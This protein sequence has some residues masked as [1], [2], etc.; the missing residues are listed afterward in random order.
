MWIGIY[1][2][3]IR[4]SFSSLRAIKIFKPSTK[5]INAN[6]PNLE[7]GH[8]NWLLA[9]LIFA[10]IAMQALGFYSRISRF[11]CGCLKVYLKTVLKDM[12]QFKLKKKKKKFVF[13][14]KHAVLKQISI[15]W[16]LNRLEQQL[17]LK[18]V[19]KTIEKQLL[20]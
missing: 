17:M 4:V 2:I 7:Q 12:L 13:L 8:A 10:D 18:N 15:L 14:I 3:N 16:H 19:R 1:N 6:I 11:L 5:N 20:I 9:N